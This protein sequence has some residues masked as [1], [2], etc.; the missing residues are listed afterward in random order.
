MR[1]VAAWLYAASSAVLAAIVLAFVFGGLNPAIAR[2]ALGIGAVTG[3]FGFW[4][5]RDVRWRWP[6]LQP[7]EWTAVALFTFFALRAFLWLVF[8]VGDEIRVLS[9]NNL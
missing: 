4:N 9:P 8:F 6:S 7:W 5:A 1:F 2:I 3:A